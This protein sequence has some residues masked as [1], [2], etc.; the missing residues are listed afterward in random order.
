MRLAK[1]KLTC[2]NKLRYLKLLFGMFKF[3]DRRIKLGFSLTH[4][5][6]HKD[7]VYSFK[8]VGIITLF[9][10]FILKLTL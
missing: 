8:S 6:E 5:K 3:F 10:V 1:P 9:W 7:L 4:Y 2:N